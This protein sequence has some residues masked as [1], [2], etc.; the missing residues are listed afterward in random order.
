M[1][2]LALAMADYHS[3]EWLPTRRPDIAEAHREAPKIAG[4]SFS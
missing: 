2:L 3:R 1:I 4:A